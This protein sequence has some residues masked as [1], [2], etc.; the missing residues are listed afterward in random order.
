MKHR[1]F[2]KSLI[3]LIIVAFSVELL[4]FNLPFWESL[5]FAHDTSFTM[6]IGNGLSSDDGHLYTVTDRQEAWI[7]LSDIHAEVKNLYLDLFSDTEFLP[8]RTLIPLTIEATDAAHADY[9]SLPE[10]EIVR[11][12]WESRY[13]RVH[14]A[15]ASD[16]IRIRIGDYAHQIRIDRIMI[17]T[18]RPFRF[19][20]MRFV[21]IL[22]IG[23]LI[24]LFRPG[25][26][27]YTMKPDLRNRRQL[28]LCVLIMLLNA[29]FLFGIGFVCMD[30]RWQE[31]RW[32]ADLEYNY[33]ADALMDGHLWLSPDPPETLLRMENPYDPVLRNRMLSEAGEEALNDY[34]WYRGRYYC[35]FGITPVILFYLPYQFLTGRW[36]CTAYPVILCAVL[37][38]PVCFLF[39]YR[40]SV[41]YFAEKL[42]LGMILLLS[43]VL[44]FSCGA[45][46]CVQVP[47]IYSLPI[48]MGLLLDLIGITCWLSASGKNGLSKPLLVA[49]AI[50]IALVAGCRPQLAIAALQAFPIFQREIRDRQFFSL[51]GLG[52]TL[53]VIVPF[54]SYGIFLMVCNVLRFDAPLEFGASYMLTDA[55][56]MHR[57]QMLY[58]IP[59]GIFEYLFQ[60][61]HFLPQFPY[62]HGVGDGWSL[63]YDHLEAINSEPLLGGFF[64]FNLIG[65]SLFFMG[66]MKKKMKEN[67]TFLISLSF[68]PIAAVIMLVDLAVA[69]LTLRYQQDFSLFLMIPAFLVIMTRMSADGPAHLSEGKSGTLSIVLAALCILTNAA[70][71]FADDRVGNLRSA[72]PQLFYTV[73]Y[74][75]FAIR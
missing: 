24:M 3:C 46:Y 35:Y 33:Y 25:S 41:R 50:C 32:P 18:V 4:Y 63:P 10:T 34:S 69:G 21:L 17:N 54:L 9:F 48:I 44:V 66:S 65:S 1:S 52:N 55:D 59:L 6:S 13:L 64:A 72:A 58:R 30:K 19:H 43:S 40:I 29:G 51:R 42:S 27:I 22:L 14:L 47:M 37:L 70:A 75:F 56:M 23:F 68:I 11:G 20:I 8:A 15:G 38:V 57:N 60:P 71:V 67:G 53:C 26:V 5:L 39:L 62:L 28:V 73:K 12:I 7:E 31:G 74:L 36:L 45:V 16:R 49:G 2:A 61:L